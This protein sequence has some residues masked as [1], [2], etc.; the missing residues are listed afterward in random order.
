MCM[1]STKFTIVFVFVSCCSK[2]NSWICYI[3]TQKK[4]SLVSMWQHRI[5]P[6]KSC[7]DKHKRVEKK[8][9]FYRQRSSVGD[10]IKLLHDWSNIC[11][12]M[13]A[14]ESGKEM[15]P[16]NFCPC[17]ASHTKC[18]LAA[19]E[20]LYWGV[21]SFT[22]SFICTNSVS[23]THCSLLL[24]NKRPTTQR[25][26]FYL[27]RYFYHRSYWDWDTKK[28]KKCF[29]NCSTDISKLEQSQKMTETLEFTSF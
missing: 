15:S 19:Q 14:K 1:F 26:L 27:S 12:C 29:F 8:R 5:T 2:A 6:W 13:R 24:N 3:F 10:W 23:F 17:V 16:R 18:D 22:E 7:C 4:K 20:L 9:K 11:D 21:F 28:E 25:R